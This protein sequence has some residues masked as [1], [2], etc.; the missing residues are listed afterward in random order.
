MSSRASCVCV[1]VQTR[2]L[3][4]SRIFIR[5]GHH[6]LVVQFEESSLNGDLSYCHIQRSKCDGRMNVCMVQ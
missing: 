3:S 2:I 5:D 6:R 4:C 1:C